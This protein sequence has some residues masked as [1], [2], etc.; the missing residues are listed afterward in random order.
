M[1]HRVRHAARPRVTLPRLRGR[2]EFVVIRPTPSATDLEEAPGARLL[3][4]GEIEVAIDGQRALPDLPR[5][6][7]PR[8]APAHLIQ[9]EKRT[10]IERGQLC[11]CRDRRVR[12][13][14]LRAAA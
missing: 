12:P 14:L 10:L 13:V 11:A 2:F 8:P 7:A 5:R 6:H 1:A 3:W 4:I 9:R